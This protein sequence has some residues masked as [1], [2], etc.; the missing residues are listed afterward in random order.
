M[1]TNAAPG[2]PLEDPDMIL[3]RIIRLSLTTTFLFV[4]GL[5]MAAVALFALPAYSG[6]WLISTV[7]LVL[8]VLALVMLARLIDRQKEAL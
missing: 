7:A 1:S 2:D 8:G 6:L 5:F 4:A 3:N